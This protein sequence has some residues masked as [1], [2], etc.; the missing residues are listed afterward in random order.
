LSGPT[1]EVSRALVL[2]LMG[3]RDRAIP[4]L[5]RLLTVTGARLTPSILRLD[6]LYDKLRGD[7]RFE[8]LTKGDP[9]LLK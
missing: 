5:K 9:E 1:I 6:P 3:D 2:A 7:P 8:P 4:E